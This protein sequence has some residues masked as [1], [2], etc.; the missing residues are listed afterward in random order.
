M[1]VTHC[2]MFNCGYLSRL[3]SSLQSV[4]TDKSLSGAR[5]PVT[6][7]PLKCEWNRRPS[8]IRILYKGPTA[9]NRDSNPRLWGKGGTFT[10][11]CSFLGGGRDFHPYMLFWPSPL[12]ATLVVTL[13]YTS[14]T[15]TCT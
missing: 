7:N 9:C 3:R 13:C 15:C 12:P 6:I 4:L 1:I 10:H 8:Y 2:G 11:I 14:C 5:Q